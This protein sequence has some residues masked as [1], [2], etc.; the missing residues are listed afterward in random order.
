M[1]SCTIQNLFLKAAIKARGAEVC[2]FQTLAGLDLFWDG[3]PSV[4]SRHAPHLFPVVGR[5]KGDILR[6]NG[7]EYRM[8]PH[9]FARGMDFKLMI[10]LLGQIG[11]GLNLGPAQVVLQVSLAGQVHRFDRVKVD[12]LEPG[13]ADG[14]QLQGHLTGLCVEGCK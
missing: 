3:D 7:Q 9:G 11:G 10:E 8:P 14:S 2:E 4:W 12:E 13:N 6:H 1:D 5:L